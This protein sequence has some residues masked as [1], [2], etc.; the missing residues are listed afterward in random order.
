VNRVVIDL[1]DP[2][3]VERVWRILEARH[4][5]RRLDPE[6]RQT[7]VRCLER[8]DPEARAE[9]E[10]KIRAEIE[11]L[12]PRLVL[13]AHWRELTPDPDRKALGFYMR[14]TQEVAA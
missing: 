10:P 8:L 11:T 1:D 9:L 6:E 4:E 3:D 13:F 14:I 12:R 2:G 5:A 7:I